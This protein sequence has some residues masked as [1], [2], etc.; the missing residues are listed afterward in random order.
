[1][2]VARTSDPVSL[3]LEPPL[4]TGWAP[5]SLQ[6][7]TTRSTLACGLQDRPASVPHPRAALRFRNRPSLSPGSYRPASSLCLC[8]H[9]NRP[10]LGEGAAVLAS[11]PS[12]GSSDAPAPPS[13]RSS[14]KR[15]REIQTP[16]RLF[17]LQLQLPTV[18]GASRLCSRSRTCHGA[19]RP[20]TARSVLPCGKGPGR[21]SRELGASLT[22]SLP[23]SGFCVLIFGPGHH[24]CPPDMEIP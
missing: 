24:Q 22:R 15:G 16:A 11:A 21:E 1:M 12:P 18:L 9:D 5:P 19:A 7:D 2:G 13:A 23:P 6:P 17:Q 8:R 3:T 4:L 20:P 10:V 14:V